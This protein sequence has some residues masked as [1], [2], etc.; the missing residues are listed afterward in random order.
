[1][2]KHLFA[3]FILIS[4]LAPAQDIKDNSRYLYIAISLQDK[5]GFA[6]IDT[7]LI[8]KDS[9][10][11][12][13]FNVGKGFGKTERQDFIRHGDSVYI[14]IDNDTILFYD[15]S[16]ETGDTFYYMSGKNMADSFVVDSTAIRRL[17]D[18]N[19]YRHWFLHTLGSNAGIPLVWIEALGEKYMGWDYSMYKVTHQ[20]ALESICYNN[21]MIMWNNVMQLDKTCN[22]DSV[23]R[24]LGIN[25]IIADKPLVYPNPCTTELNIRSDSEMYYV[26]CN[27]NGQIFSRGYSDGV[28]GTEKL[29]PGMYLLFLYNAH[30]SYQVYFEK[31]D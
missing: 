30:I 4:T 21:D 7:L 16:I 5:G 3:L 29:Y 24:S 2:K 18:G 19:F 31:T 10:N 20:P 15:Y 26:I 13:E 25:E 9:G 6:I 14:L 11:R 23:A 8:T 12:T 27:L 17:D 1:M 22:F 28:I